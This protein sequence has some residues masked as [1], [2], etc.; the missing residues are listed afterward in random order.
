M[1]SPS[2]MTDYKYDNFQK[3]S[4]IKSN[5]IYE[6]SDIDTSLKPN[7]KVD[8]RIQKNCFENDFEITVGSKNGKFGGISYSTKKITR[9]EDHEA[10]IEKTE[11]QNFE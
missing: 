1:I 4:N 5:L 6:T 11:T 3:K 9:C 10:P 8:D 2:I 7:M